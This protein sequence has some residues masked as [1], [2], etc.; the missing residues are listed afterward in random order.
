[1][2]SLTQQQIEDLLTINGR[3]EYTDIA[4]RLNQNPVTVSNVIRRMR[5]WGNIEIDYNSQPFK[6]KLI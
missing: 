5:K 2:V 3:M 4:K 6:V 1:M